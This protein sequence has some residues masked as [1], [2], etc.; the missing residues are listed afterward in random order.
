MDTFILKLTENTRFTDD[1]LFEFCSANKELQIERDV[2]GNL[3]VMSPSG[4]RSSYI[5]ARILAQI[6]NWS[7]NQPNPGVTFGPDG[8]FLLPDGSMKA[9]DVAW[10][11]SSIWDELNDEQK[12]K[13]APIAPHF[14][15][16]LKSPSDS[17]TA[18]KKKMEEWIA[19]GVLLAWLI[20]PEL[21]KAFI[22]KPGQPVSEVNSFE[23][24]LGGED[25]LPGFKLDLSKLK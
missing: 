17:N 16:E 24:L 12:N 2:N 8:G 15:I 11:P 10:L 6:V 5:N 22:Y 7:D 23:V 14:V 4:S 20:D 25:V 18:L 3:I 1:E 19:N 13:F 21:K 9:G